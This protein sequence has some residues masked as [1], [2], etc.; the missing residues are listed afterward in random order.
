[1]HYIH[2]QNIIGKEIINFRQKVKIQI[3]EHRTKMLRKCEVGTIYIYGTQ[4]RYST[5]IY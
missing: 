4:N 1:M 3:I 5:Q 2:N